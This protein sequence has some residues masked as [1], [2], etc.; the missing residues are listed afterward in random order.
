M[1][2]SA[3]RN[4]Y[5][6]STIV[7]ASRGDG[8]DVG[9]SRQGVLFDQL[10]SVLVV[11]TCTIVADGGLGAETPRLGALAGHGKSVSVN[12][13]VEVGQDELAPAVDDDLDYLSR[14]VTWVVAD[15]VDERPRAVLIG[16]DV[17]P[18]GEVVQ[19]RYFDLFQTRRVNSRI[20]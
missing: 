7:A 3:D 20:K 18:V 13:D 2:S 4:Q 5:G 9:A 12:V 14:G 15:L 16:R 19:Q 6:K 8:G 10:S 1:T 17:F 11:W